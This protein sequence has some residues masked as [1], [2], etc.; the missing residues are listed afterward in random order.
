MLELHLEKPFQYR[1]SGKFVGK[2]AAWK[3]MERQLVDYELIVMEKGT[4]Y[5][6]DE[7]RKYEVREGEYLIMEPTRLQKGWRPSKCRFYW[8]HFL[9]EVS[10]NEMDP[11]RQR[12]LVLPR[13]GS[14]PNPDRAFVMLRQLQ[15]TDLRYMDARYNGFL[16][17]GVLCELTAQKTG[18]SA[19]GEEALLQ[20]VDDYL[21]KH[22]G[23]AVS[24][25]DLAG[26]FGYHEKY[27]SALF[28]EKAGVSVKKYVDGRKMERAKYL[29]LNTGAYVA[30]IAEHLG[31]KDVQNFY[32][33]FK[34]TAD[35]TPT[36][37]REQYC[38]KQEF[39][40]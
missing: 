23:E 6:E 24:V 26:A 1:W 19:G 30:E 18:N 37:F 36:E 40:V 34:K 21:L 15:D 4:L 25:G 31:Y 27:F 29:L 33:V 32:H 13:Q 3:H 17:T 8:A 2:E 11:E 9:P 38:K 35:C 12:I 16:I 22:L 7:W 10:E 5:I 39:N 20:R 14:L 28:K